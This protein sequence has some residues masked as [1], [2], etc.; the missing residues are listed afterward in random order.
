MLKTRAIINIVGQ[1]RKFLG[2]IDDKLLKEAVAHL[3][4]ST[5]VWVVNQAMTK[6]YDADHQA[7]LLGQ[8]HDSLM[9]QHNYRDL[10]AMESFC[11]LAKDALEPRLSTNDHKFYIKTDIKIGFDASKMYETTISNLKEDVEKL[12]KLK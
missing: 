11:K 7:E 10:N 5:S 4:Q 2:T 3:P 8:V 6:I 1:P 12:C 9:F